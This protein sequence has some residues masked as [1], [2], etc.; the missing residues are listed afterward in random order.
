MIIISIIVV[1]I[2]AACGK[3]EA[4][5]K[6]ED[7]EKEAIVL[8]D[9]E[10]L[11]EDELVAT[12]NGK[13]LF[14]NTYNHMY[15]QIKKLV[16]DTSEE[17]DPNNVKQLTIESILEK[18]LFMQMAEK[19]GITI[20]DKEITETIEEIKKVNIVGYERMREQFNYTEEA[21]E[22]QMKLELARKQYIQD[23]VKVDVSENEVEEMYD[24]LKE[25]IENIA[26]YDQIKGE[27]QKTLELQKI[28]KVINKLLEK[29][30]EESEI[31]VL[32]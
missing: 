26:D 22:S 18:E 32:L 13:E 16:S 3:E 15:L 17:V 7:H 6:N 25:E 31:D 10:K 14:G 12:V 21:I 2:L 27:L 30:E 20:S 5:E 29:F 19:E 23:F 11:P 1:L 24:D 8:T 4:D 28:D 9:E